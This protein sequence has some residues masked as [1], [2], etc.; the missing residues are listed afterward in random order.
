MGNPGGC[1]PVLEEAEFDLGYPPVS[2][3]EEVDNISNVSIEPS[4]DIDVDDAGLVEDD[5]SA[6]TGD[7]VEVR[8]PVLNENTAWQDDLIDVFR[9]M[10][11]DEVC[12]FEVFED[13]VAEFTTRV[14]KELG[15]R[16]K[17]D[18]DRKKVKRRV[19]DPLDCKALQKLYRSN[20]KKALRVILSEES[21]FC[22]LD[23]ELVASHYCSEPA[24][25][26]NDKSYLD[27]CGKASSEV[28][29][30]RFTSKEVLSK[31]KKCDN[32]SPGPD[33]ITYNGWKK[34]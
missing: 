10:Y 2:E 18:S 20:R 26:S 12:N 6:D 15:I 31:L 21:E 30:S 32:T 5:V 4:F 11:G 33:G 17:A 14:R 13:R 3:N 22:N 24:D 7:G 16:D 25:E 23:P 27:H 9:N 1:E 19:V 29:C 34:D 8:P 28:I